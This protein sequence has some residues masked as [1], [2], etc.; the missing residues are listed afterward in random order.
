MTPSK[1]LLAIST[2]TDSATGS[3]VSPLP[4]GAFGE[5][6]V[7]VSAPVIDNLY[8][9]SRFTTPIIPGDNNCV[10]PPSS[11]ETWTAPSVTCTAVP[12]SVTV[13]L[14]VVPFTTAAR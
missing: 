2:K 14:N 3:G 1:L 4:A 11:V 7:R 5:S 8:C 13:T 6:I 9:W 12:D 10:A